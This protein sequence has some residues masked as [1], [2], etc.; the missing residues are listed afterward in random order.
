MTQAESG[1]GT[2]VSP[3]VAKLIAECVLD[4]NRSDALRTDLAG[5]LQG[6]GLTLTPD[7]MDKVTTYLRNYPARP[8]DA[9]LVGALKSTW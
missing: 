2:M 7:E 4:T 8:S 6:M 9:T 5:T 1:G 3:A